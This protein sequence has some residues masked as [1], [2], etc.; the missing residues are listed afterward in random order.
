MKNSKKSLRRFLKPENLTPDKIKRFGFIGLIIL[1]GF[2][3]V[4]TFVPFLQISEYI[5]FAG[6]HNTKSINQALEDVK[7]GVNSDDLFAFDFAS[8]LNSFVFSADGRLLLNLYTDSGK[9]AS[10]LQIKEIN[11]LESEKWKT[12]RKVQLDFPY[13]TLKT[14]DDKII[15][16]GNSNKNLKKEESTFEVALFDFEGQKLDELKLPDSYLGV[17]Q[18]KNSFIVTSFKDD[19][20]IRVDKDKFYSEKITSNSQVKNSQT[21]Q[22]TRLTAKC[23]ASGDSFVCLNTEGTALNS[24]QKSADQ[25]IKVQKIRDFPDPLATFDNL[26]DGFFA[27][28]QN[29]KALIM[30]GDQSFALPESVGYPSSFAQTVFKDKK[31]FAFASNSDQKIRVY[32]I[33]NNEASEIFSQKYS[34]SITQ[35]AFHPNQIKLMLFN[36]F[37]SEDFT[38]HRLK[39]SMVEFN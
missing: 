16:V 38:N 1:I 34:T 27:V 13:S 21:N 26:F 31:I 8:D 24:F 33:D 15:A 37:L 20:Y 22:L 7:K 4:S 9:N 30:I 35:L 36:C 14:F 17:F 25:N 3:V 29:H 12:L 32:K 6:H 28:T 18:N 2:G 23:V 5:P 19:F 10:V 39:V 11:S